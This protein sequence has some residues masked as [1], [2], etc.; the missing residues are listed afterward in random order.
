VNGKP[1]DPPVGVE[2]GGSVGLW[3]FNIEVKG[4]QSI[5][6]VN[7]DLSK[8]G[9][10]WASD[11]MEATVGYLSK[12]GSQLRDG[13]ITQAFGSTT[14]CSVRSE[15]TSD[16]VSAQRDVACLSHVYEMPEDVTNPPSFT[17]RWAIPGCIV[18]RFDTICDLAAQ[19]R[20]LA[21]DISGPHGNESVGW[22]PE[23]HVRDTAPG[24]PNHN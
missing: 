19:D 1:S 2:G 9:R 3:C 17:P 7:K 24:S 20:K 12:P 5:R 23:P 8:G 14:Q 10:R 11:D 4:A 6:A 15:T 21:P 18:Q 13:M 16:D 22:R